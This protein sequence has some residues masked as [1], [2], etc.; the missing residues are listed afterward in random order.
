MD[1]TEV[2]LHVRVTP[3][4]SKNE[5]LDR[6]GDTVRIKITAPPV[7]GAANKA[8]IEFVASQLGIKRSQ[9]AIVAGE[10]SRDKILRISGVTAQ[11]INRA[12]GEE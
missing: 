4:G 10:K 12:F 11:D 1:V 5:V 7:E 2:T 3:R 9:V 6:L 8:C